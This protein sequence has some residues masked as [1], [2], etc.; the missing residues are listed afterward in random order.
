MKKGFWLADCAGWQVPA[1][2]FV[3][4]LPSPSPLGSATHETLIVC[5][6]KRRGNA[7]ESLIKGSTSCISRMPCD[8]IRSRPT[9]HIAPSASM[10]RPPAKAPSIPLMLRLESCSMPNLTICDCRSSPWAGPLFRGGLFP[11]NPAAKPSSESV[12]PENSQHFP[13]PRFGLLTSQHVHGPSTIVRFQAQDS[14]APCGPPCLPST[15]SLAQTRPS[16]L[17]HEVLHIGRRW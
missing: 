14:A 7:F 15:P 11:R 12:R 16:E 10:P 6:H 5:T 17:M 8:W 1:V 3:A 4:S 13:L 9:R 2:V